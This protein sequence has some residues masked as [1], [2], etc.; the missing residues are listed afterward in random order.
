VILP[1]PIAVETGDGSP[2][3]ARGTL[4]I[5]IWLALALATFAIE[6]LVVLDHELR[7]GLVPAP[8][9]AITTFVMAS[10][11]LY[12][13]PALFSPWQPWTAT[14]VG[15]GWTFLLAD[16][17][18]MLVIGRAAER[19]GGSAS[20]AAGL[21][22]AAALAGLLFCAVARDGQLTGSAPLALGAIGLAWALLP[23][24]RVRF[25]LAWWAVVAAGLRPLVAVPLHTVALGYLALHALLSPER[26]HLEVLLVDTAALLAGFLAGLA[27]RVRGPAE[28]GQPP[29]SPSH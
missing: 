14:L 17:A 24:G 12:A 27:A 23:A 2:L 7:W 6:R 15:N 4:V 1:L 21:L 8:L 26:P 22:A 16:L 20:L 18:V 25:G 13:D 29:A 19:L 9:F 10:W 5:W 3:P 11:S 28:G